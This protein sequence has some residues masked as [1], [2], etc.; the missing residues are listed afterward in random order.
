M[1]SINTDPKKIKEL[2][3]RGVENILPLPGELEKELL[4]GRQLKLYNGIDPTAPTLHIGHGASLLKLR[5]FQELGHE[6]IV[7]LGSFTAMIGDPTDKKA[8]RVK[9]TK[10]QV[11]DNL[12]KY[13]DQIG[14]ILDIDK[15][16]FVFNGDWLEPL[17]FADVVEL[18]SEFTVQQM[19]ERDMFE[20]RIKSG[21]P[22]YLHEFLYPLMQGY[23]SVALG[24]DIEVGGNDQTFNML[25]GRTMLKRRG[26]EKFVVAMKLLTDP[27][28]K[29]MGKSEGNMVSLSDEPADMYGKVMSW[30]DSLILPAFEICTRRPL[31]GI[32]ERAAKDPMQTKKDL[33]REIV[34]MYHSEEAAK[35]AEQRFVT[36]F[37]EGGV[38]EDV[39]E[40]EAG[41]GEKIFDAILKPLESSKTELR[42]LFENGAVSIVG[43]DKVNDPNTPLS[44][45]ITL[46]IGKKRFLKIKIK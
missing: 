2:L 27:T 4:S 1:S 20:E 32:A 40:V 46:R 6:V 3:T 10:E 26:K 14:K 23:D 7:L 38:P 41:A 11:Q 33:A 22:I 15:T 43:G 13:K 8:A 36:A 21:I 12:R 42:R 37:S 31:D 18:A 39:L 17:T 35:E 25:A 44:A 34:R 16:K 19:M 24:V 28:G 5:E 9:L 30:P 29:K 45:D